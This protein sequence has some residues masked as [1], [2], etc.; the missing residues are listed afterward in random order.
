L[1]AFSPVAFYEPGEDI[2]H[3][4]RTCHLERSEK[5][6]GVFTKSFLNVSIEENK[7]TFKN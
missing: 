1:E 7:K 5:T 2:I 4:H 6:P 3:I